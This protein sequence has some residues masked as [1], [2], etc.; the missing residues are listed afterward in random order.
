MEDIKEVRHT[1]KHGIYSIVC[2]EDPHSDTSKRKDQ[3]YNDGVAA[4]YEIDLKSGQKIALDL[5]G[6]QYQFHIKHMTVRPWLEYWHLYGKDLEQ[7]DEFSTARDIHIDM[8]RSFDKLSHLTINMYILEGFD[9]W[10]KKEEEKD[11]LLSSQHS[12]P[13]LTNDLPSA[14][15]LQHELLDRAKA[16]LSARLTDIDNNSTITPSPNNIPY[17][18][19][20][21]RHPRRMG[22]SV[23]VTHDRHMLTPHISPLRN[24]NWDLLRELILDKDVP[25]KEK[26]EAKDLLQCRAVYAPWG[27]SRIVFLSDTLP[28]K[29]TKLEWVSE[30]PHWK[31]RLGGGS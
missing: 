14:L 20:G 11:E 3:P 5:T 21:L 23:F 1:L 30:N 25:Y 8:M 4:V 27:D 2:Y 17:P 22:T 7:R 10:I 12:N 16:A 18:T 28:G 13:L 31:V 26:K 24:F 19:S 15:K 29:E 9:S 6:A